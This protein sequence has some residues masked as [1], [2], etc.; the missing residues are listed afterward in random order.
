M[1]CPLMHRWILD[2]SKSRS[3]ELD[4]AAIVVNVTVA[5]LP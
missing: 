3:Q 4:A 5:M 2:H 1:L